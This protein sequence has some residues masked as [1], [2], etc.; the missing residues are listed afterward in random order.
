VSGRLLGIA[1][2]A[3]PRAPMEVLHTA[4][5]TPER[6]V[7]GDFRGVVKPGGRGRRQVSL[8]ELRD[9][10]AA[11]AEVG[12][13]A[14]WFQ[15]RANLLVDGF[16]LPQVPG[17][18]VRIGSVLLEVTVE[19][20]PCIRM[21]AVAPGL[22]AALVPDWRGGALARVITGGTIAVGDDVRGEER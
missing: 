9:W 20:D 10:R 2:R 7:E 19:C 21:E 16:D 14:P 8:L 6:G 17:A 12:A 18:L 11:L 5:V 13:D 3:R 15:R 22:E 4:L 1:R